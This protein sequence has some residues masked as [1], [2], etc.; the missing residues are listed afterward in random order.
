MNAPFAILLMS[1]TWGA[2]DTSDRADAITAA[3]KAFEAAPSGPWYDR[4]KDV[5]QPVSLRVGEYDLEWLFYPLFWLFVIMIVAVVAILTWLIVRAILARK[6]LAPAGG[7]PEAVVPV[8]PES[9]EAL[10]FLGRR[11][12]DDLLGQARRHYEQGNY[13]EA[14]VYLF[15]Y[16][17]VQLDKGALVQL[18]SGKTNR[19]YLRELAGLQPL[20]R[21]VEHTMLTFEDVFFGGRGLDRAGFETC[22]SQLGDFESLLAQAQG[23][24]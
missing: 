18:S 19:Q 20:K 21:L 12:R 10:H 17:L 2:I 4:N 5:L 11:S 13:A 15:S 24:P 7:H 22:W 9:V 16:Q 1:V 14:I 3:R 6:R 8:V 23:S